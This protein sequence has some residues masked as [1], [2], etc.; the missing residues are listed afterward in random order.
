MIDLKKQIMYV[1]NPVKLFFFANKE[2]FHFS[3]VSLHVWKKYL[4]VKWPDLNRKTL[5][6][7]F[8]RMGYLN[9]AWQS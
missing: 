9:K 2:F 3:L 7:M 4:I 8:Y 5:K 1:A 6:K